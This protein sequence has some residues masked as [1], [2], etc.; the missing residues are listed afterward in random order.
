MITVFL[1]LIWILAIVLIRTKPNERSAFWYAIYLI[2]IGFSFLCSAI[3]RELIPSLPPQTNPILIE[4]LKIIARFFSS[5]SY[6]STLYSFHKFSITHADFYNKGAKGLERFLVAF[7]G[8]V[9]LYTFVN[10][11][12]S[13]IYIYLD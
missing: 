12:Q 6:Y 8:S 1:I 4:L 13:F 10:I 7:I 9:V 5:L 2:A 11:K 3:T